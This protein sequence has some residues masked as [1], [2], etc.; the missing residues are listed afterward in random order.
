MERRDPVRLSELASASSPELRQAI[1]SLRANN[2]SATMVDALRERLSARLGPH[3]LR[4]TAVSGLPSSWL[5][6]L[7]GAGMLALTGFH[8]LVRHVAEARPAPPEIPV[9]VDTA[10]ETMSDTVADS[11]A[12]TPLTAA[13]VTAPPA[14]AKT[15]STDLTKTQAAGASSLPP[16]AAQ[17]PSGA[18][19]RPRT[20]TRI[21]RVTRARPGRSDRAHPDAE[22][23]LL[24][25]SQGLL[26]ADPA[27]ALALAEH[28]ADAYPRGVFAQE[29]EVLAI[30]ALLKRRMR[31]LA[32]TRAERFLKD[33]AGSPYAFR[34]ALLIEQA[35]RETPSGGAALESA[36]TEPTPR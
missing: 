13:E 8:V 31:A 36:R 21:A 17:A 29:R 10:S 12:S 18:A 20:V 11:S 2:G 9:V 23:S 34:I 27:A 3:A 32:L 33:Y 7:F 25:R 15:R 24:Q 5:L 35:P 26:R 1:H 4:A 30:E 19:A 6:G 28:H 14:A 22:L 16:S